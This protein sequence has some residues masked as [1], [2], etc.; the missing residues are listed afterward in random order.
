M[1]D[2]GS[3]GLVRPPRSCSQRDFECRRQR[4]KVSITASYA[5]GLFLNGRDRAII[6]FVSEIGYATTRQLRR[7]FWDDNAPRAAAERLLELWRLW[8]LDR[9]PFFR[10]S[11]YGLRPQLVY[12]LGRAGV[13]MMRDLDDNVTRRRGTLLMPHNVLLCEALVRLV[14]AARATN[15]QHN[16]NFYGEA[17]SRATFKWDG[18]W[19][20]MRPD[21]LIDLQLEGQDLPFYVEFDRNTRPISH[22]SGKVKQY[23]LYRRSKEWKSR[24]SVFPGI[25]VIVWSKY[26][27][28]GLSEDEA[29]DRRGGRVQRRLD[30]IIKHL[31]S[32]TRDPALRWFC[33]RLDLVGKAPWHVVTAD[34]LKRA[35]AFFTHKGHR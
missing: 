31:Q 2:R 27:V 6:R 5:R 18:Q 14:E 15:R 4:P 9:Q 16:L 13:K 35:P 33:Q 1:K 10:L 21:G 28:D 11:D 8:V 7:L 20:K 30:G 12:M 25:L 17:V 26:Q 19:I 23:G 32:A 24:Y 3:F 34:G 22:F 29:A